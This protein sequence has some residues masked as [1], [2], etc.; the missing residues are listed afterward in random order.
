MS[1]PD[2]NVTQLLRAV[3]KGDDR[4]RERLMAA[5]YDDLHRLAASHLRGERANH[6]L[7]PT[8]LVH[9]A[10]LRLIN[11]RLTDWNDRLHFFSIASTIIRRILIDHARERR[12]L[13]RGGVAGRV[14]ID[15][16]EPAA[17]EQD[18]DLLAL[19]E[20]LRDLAQLDERQSRIVELRFFGGCTI[21][22][23]AE[24]LG[25][26][27]RTVDRDWMAA[28]AWLYCRLR[29]SETEPGDDR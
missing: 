13:K 23:I 6:T 19:D 21:E 3:S 14:S 1:T 29:D 16:H 2:P 24:L 4:D 28:K 26:G 11:Q 22:E 25:V 15:T 5:V 9:E 12:A 20:A 8:A 18:L 10:Y 17:P 27:K 7:Q